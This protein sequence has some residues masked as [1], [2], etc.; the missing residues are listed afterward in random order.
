MQED[1][2]ALVKLGD[3]DYL[4][5]CNIRPDL[6]WDK[7][8]EKDLSDEEFEKYD[9]LY[10]GTGAVV[11]VTV[12]GGK[13]SLGDFYESEKQIDRCPGIDGYIYAITEDGSIDSFRLKYAR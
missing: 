8:W 2:R 6:D 4:L 13:I 5:P 7:I 10:E 1:H 3:A 9:K 11:P 12:K